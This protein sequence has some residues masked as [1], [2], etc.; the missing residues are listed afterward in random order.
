MQFARRKVVEIEK[1]FQ[2]KKIL[3]EPSLQVVI[4]TNPEIQMIAMK[5]GTKAFQ[6]KEA[7]I[8]WIDC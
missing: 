8:R 2:K 1:D 4:C 3:T 5:W 6:T 7:A